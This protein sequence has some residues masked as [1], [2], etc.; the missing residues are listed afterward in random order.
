MLTKLEDLNKVHMIGIASGV[1]SFVATYL[2]NLGVK[3]TASELNQDNQASKDWIEKGVLF[4]GGHNA[5][6]ITDD[7]DLVVFPNGPIPGNPECERAQELKLPTATVGQILGLISKRFKTIA[8][9]GTHG[10]TTTSAL[11]V[12]LLYKEYRELPNFVIGEEILDINKSYNFNPYNKYLVIEAC[13]YKRQFL[14]RVPNPYISAIVN[15]DI[16][17]TDY[18]KDQEDYNSAFKEFISNTQ[19]ATVIDSRGKNIGDI[20]KNLDIKV[21]DCKDIE[22]LYTDITAGLVGEHNRENVLRACGVS[23]ALGIFP[24]IEDYPGVKSRFEYIGR[25]IHDSKI[26]LDYAH[27]PKKIRACLQGAKEQFPDKKIVLIWQPH[28]FERCI[29]FKDDFSKSL[30]DADVVMIPNIYAPVR[31]SEEYREKLSEEEFVH[32]LK[33]RNR[34]KDIRYTK[35]FDNTAEQLEEFDEEAVLVFA[36][37]G[38]LKEIFKLMEIENE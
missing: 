1:S 30:D 28:S 7:L 14:D 16:D 24:D 38:N 5:K 21:I 31:E 11:I 4:K 8:V 12:W 2:L 19:F 29:S 20:V 13:E 17:H 15:V 23:N 26:F 6:Y 32:Y 9:A 36:S 22:P 10:K 35:S 18:Y 25:T 34:D 37:A 33:E 3:V 27:N